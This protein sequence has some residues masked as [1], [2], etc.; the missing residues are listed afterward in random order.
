PSIVVGIFIP[1]L[2]SNNPQQATW[3]TSPEK[4]ELLKEL[5][6]DER[7]KE[8]SFGHAKSWKE[9][10]RNSRVWLG[11]LIYLCITVC[12]YGL[13]FWLPQIIEHT[14][15]KDKFQIGLV[16]AIPWITA[17]AGMIY[18]GLHSDRTGERKL[19]ISFA[20]LLA[21]IGFVAS[22]F[23]TANP[24]AVVVTLSM[25]ATGVMCLISSF[26]S[27]PT[28]ILSGS[29]AAAGIA[30]I[31]SVGNLGGYISPELF[32]WLNQHFDFTIALRAIG[33]FSAL[34]GILVY[35]NWKMAKP[36]SG[37]KGTT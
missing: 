5:E 36:R 19:H 30:W 31:N 4:R 20:A 26:W 12:L 21:T 10:L 3:L 29:A 33:G 37:A 17:A 18:F 11:C 35:G 25:A 23:T 7:I 24:Y 13:S 32:R 28:A 34:A 1:W 14:I 9:A 6:A 16:S 8:Q 27:L 15:T 22:S 2:L